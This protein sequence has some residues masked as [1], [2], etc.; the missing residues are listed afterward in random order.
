MQQLPDLYQSLRSFLLQ[1]TVGLVRGL[2]LL[3]PAEPTLPFLM[4]LSEADAANTV[5]PASP[6]RWLEL[7]SQT[8]FG[9]YAVFALALYWT[10]EGEII[11]RRLTSEVLAKHRTELRV[12]RSPKSRGKI[13]GDSRGQAILMAAVG[14]VVTIAFLAPGIPNALLLGLLMAIFEVVPDGPAAAG[15]HSRP[16]DDRWARA[17]Q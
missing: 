13:G 9:V 17:G 8:L 16:V 10:M 3:L 12:T 6:W 14:G 11:I 7:G 4:A 1:L 15:R 5:E 2:A